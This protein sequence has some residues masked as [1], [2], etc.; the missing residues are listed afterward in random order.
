MSSRR[1]LV[2][3]G[4]GVISASVSRLAVELGWELTLLNRGT[5][6]WR[7]P[8]EGAR[9]LVADAA[10]PAS[11]RTAIGGEDFDVVANFQAFRPD[12]V[13]SDIETFEG[14][15]GQYLFISSAS[16][17][18]KPIAQLPITE[19]TP[20]KN[21]YW[22]YSRNK[23]AAEELLV[24]AYRER[25]F[26]ITIVRPSHTYDETT[27]PLWGGWTTLQR[28]IDGKPIVVHGDGT[29]WWTMTH[30]RDFAVAFL[31]LWGNPHAIGLPVHIVADEHLT[32]DG[33]AAAAGAAL[34][35]EPRL[36]HVASEAIARE[37]PPIGPWLLGDWAHSVC[38]D[39]SR[40]KSLVP[41]WVATTSFA[42]GAREFVA[43]HLAHPDRQLVDRELDAAWDRL[44]G[45]AA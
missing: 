31:G 34:G 40:I 7:A 27:V 2:I 4:N 26:P 32:W 16:A 39:T 14:R 18:Q 24:R 8:I 20:L 33:I 6:T 25:D 35:V 5:Q 11:I 41:G 36:V 13:V 44:V 30:S 19:A 22:D 37:H 15:A 42:Q 23:I 29:S 45:Q 28:L 12:Q 43:W 17:Y 3:G 38:F 9:M 21:P 10:D 1:A